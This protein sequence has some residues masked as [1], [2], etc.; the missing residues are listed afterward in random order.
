MLLRVSAPLPSPVQP[1]NERAEALLS[2]HPPPTHPTHTAEPA[3]AAPAGCPALLDLTQCTAARI[4][5][6][7]DA[8]LKPQSDWRLP[9]TLTCSCGDCRAAQVR[10]AAAQHSTACLPRAHPNRVSHTAAGGGPPHRS[11]PPS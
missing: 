10:A 7:S 9:V 6:T 1:H 8:L 5:A 11:V 3:A 2:P 4:K